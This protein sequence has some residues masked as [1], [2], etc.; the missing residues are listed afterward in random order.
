MSDRKNGGGW[1]SPSKNSWG[2]PSP[3][4]A[5]PTAHGPTHDPSASD[6]ATTAAPSQGI[7]AANAEGSAGSFARSDHDHKLRTSEGGGADLGIGNVAD[8]EFLKRSGSNIIGETPSG[9][10]TGTLVLDAAGGGDATKVEDLPALMSGGERIFVVPGSYTTASTVQL[11]GKVAHFQSLGSKEDTTFTC[12]HTSDMFN[13]EEGSTFTDIA[14]V[15]PSSN[16][17]N[18]MFDPQGGSSDDI[19]F[20]RCDFSTPGSFNY[21]F[22]DATGADVYFENCTANWEFV[23]GFMNSTNTGG[24]YADGFEISNLEGGTDGLFFIGTGKTL[25]LHNFSCA[26]KDSTF[27]AGYVG[28]CSMDFRDVRITH[29]GTPFQNK[30]I[31]FTGA[32]SGSTWRLHDVQGFDD[33]RL[34][35]STTDSIYCRHA[36]VGDWLTTA[37]GSILGATFDMDLA[38]GRVITATTATLALDGSERRVQVDRDGAG[39]CAITGALLSKTGPPKFEVGSVDENASPGNWSFNRNGSGSDT[40][41]NGSATAYVSTTPF[42]AVEFG[43]DESNSIWTLESIYRS[44]LSANV[45]NPPTDAEIDSVTGSTPGAAGIGAG[46]S[47]LLEDND[48][49]NLYQVHS[50]GTDWYTYAGAK[51]V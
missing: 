25:K 4:G 30:L 39:D 29:S 44:M 51:A 26:F 1:G 40:V 42:E 20:T 2:R 49:D 43:K 13:M 19:R 15:G 32:V 7:G 18:Y 17:V 24:V 48:S 14:F 34:T 9:G 5:T 46:Y 36:L 21:R 10:I 35:A 33:Q 41:G 47:V 8:G 50:D 6:P 16:S 27:L 31:T 45:S 28:T 3:P 22:I 23:N 38:S 11:A 12:G 37:D